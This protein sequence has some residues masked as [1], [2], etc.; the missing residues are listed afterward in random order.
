MKGDQGIKGLRGP[1]GTSGQ[2]GPRGFTGV[3]GERGPRGDPGQTGLVGH[4]GSQGECG[5]PG[6]RG[7]TG[8]P[9]LPGILPEV[10][11]P[12]FDGVDLSMVMYNCCVIINYINIIIQS[13]PNPTELEVITDLLVTRNSTL[14][15]TLLDASQLLL[16]LLAEY[17]CFEN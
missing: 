1:K 11:C 5:R 3:A 7:P 10:N 16:Q 9:G 15:C 4:T 2:P 17:F 13:Q 12:R 8:P 14:A 6:R